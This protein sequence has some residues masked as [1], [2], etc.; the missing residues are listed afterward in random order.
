MS[1]NN[2]FLY[3]IYTKLPNEQ[4]EK[5]SC[6]LRLKKDNV[7]I[8]IIV[9]IGIT[10]GI[11]QPTKFPLIP[12]Y[13]IWNYGKVEK[14][15]IDEIG[16]RKN[17]W[18]I[19][20]ALLTHSKS[21]LIYTGGKGPFTECTCFRASLASIAELD[22]LLIRQASSSIEYSPSISNQKTIISHV[23]LTWICQKSYSN[24]TIWMY[25]SYTELS[26]IKTVL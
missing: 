22:L 23:L 16:V 18:W 7:I 21:P 8:V 4:F 6:W 2:T 17:I 20:L 9:A 13:F 11:W 24:L 10:L 26:R 5:L 1:N 19:W 3:L 12:A 15:W 25:S 14:K